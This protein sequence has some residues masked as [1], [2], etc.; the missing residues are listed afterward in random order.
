M[1]LLFVIFLQN[2]NNT[3][4]FHKWNVWL[5]DTTSTS[6]NSSSSWMIVHQVRY[7]IRF[8]SYRRSH[9]FLFVLG[10]IIQSVSIWVKSPVWVEAP[11]NKLARR[12]GSWKT[13]G[14][15]ALLEVWE[16]SFCLSFGANWGSWKV[17]ILAP[18]WTN[19]IS[20]V[21]RRRLFYSWPSE[22]L[23]R[24]Q[25]GNSWLTREQNTFHACA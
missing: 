13:R 8:T 21:T 3:H 16:I 7:L 1:P 14:E 11:R 2:W 15:I 4:A 23:I 22:N 6:S 17:I 12:Q 10:K 25:I 18:F 24:V 19:W 9:L 5:Y 20:D